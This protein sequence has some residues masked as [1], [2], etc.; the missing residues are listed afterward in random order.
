MSAKNVLSVAL[1]MFVA[2]SLVVLSIKSLRQTSPPAEAVGAL[3][4]GDASA[5]S[6][7]ANRIVV[8]YFHGNVRCPTCE[9]IEAYTKEAIEAGFPEPL[10]DGRLEWRT[11]SYEQPGN[12]HFQA[13]YQLA[14]PCVVLV[15]MQGA[16]QT[17]WRSLPEVWQHVT[18][19]PAFTQLVQTNVRE[20]LDYLATPA[21]C[22]Q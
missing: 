2:A 16:K 20:F 8:Y 14:A 9:C 11:V 7:R 10:G 3:G 15:R 21:A 12:E 17:E 22:C 4:T 19:K 5:V 13:D 18:D 1:L 6:S